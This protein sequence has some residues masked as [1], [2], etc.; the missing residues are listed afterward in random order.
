VHGVKRRSAGEF[1]FPIAASTLFAITRGDPVLFGIP[2]LTLTLA[3]AAAALAGL[4]Y[5]RTRYECGDGSKTLE[6]SV[7]FFGVAVLTAYV[8]LLVLADTGRL[9][10][11][12]VSVTYGVLVTLLEAVS[13]DGTDNLCIPFAGYLVLAASLREGADVLAATLLVATLLLALCV[14]IAW[15]R[16]SNGIAARATVPAPAGRAAGVR[17]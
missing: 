5:G 9:Q 12:L 1:Y 4:H 11:V 7:A 3:D 15:P 13:P 10:A 2:I 17:R 14:S 16:R 8:P 6:G